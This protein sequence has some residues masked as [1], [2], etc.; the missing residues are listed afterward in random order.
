MPSE[1]IDMHF[2]LDFCADPT[3]Y[4]KTARTADVSVLAVSC[5]PDGYK[6]ARAAAETGEGKMRETRI[7]LVPALGL[8]PWWVARGELATG[9][10]DEFE[11]LA[12]SAPAFGE[13]GLDFDDRH[14]PPSS[15]VTQLVAFTRCCRAVNAS[16]RA[17]GIRKPLSLHAFRATGAVLD[18]LER[19][20]CLEGC[21]CIFH[22]FADSQA[23][24]SR[25]IGA[26]CWFS[27]N[28]RTV[29][30]KRWKEY[31]GLVPADRL[32]L[33]TD[34]P[35]DASSQLAAGEHRASLEATV[36]RLAELLGQ[37]AEDIA[38]QTTRNS[39]ALLFPTARDC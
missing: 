15:H 12:P 28:E 34:L 16:A 31:A 5:E 39:R 24:L 35:E 4:A 29:R 37:D 11:R 17:A 9:A 21:A 26:G 14:T 2:H 8:H 10:F 22:W 3:A 23:E 19:T 38:T 1:L 18:V 25:A 30:T 32:L 6:T 20:G 13:L 27:V 36:R 33:E 7:P